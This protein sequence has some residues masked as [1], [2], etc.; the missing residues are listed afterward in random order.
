[1]VGWNIALASPTIISEPNVTGQAINSTY[2]VPFIQSR[3]DDSPGVFAEILCWHLGFALWLDSRGAWHLGL[4]DAGKGSK[5]VRKRWSDGSKIYVRY[6]MIVGYHFFRQICVG[7]EL[8]MFGSHPNGWW[9]YPL[10]TVLRNLTND[11]RKRMVLCWF[12]LWGIWYSD[13]Q[14]PQVVYLPQVQHRKM[15]KGSARF[16]ALRICW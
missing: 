5:F 9:G 3:D 6:N 1:M 13:G 12:P 7:L 8:D 16:K 10:P 14:Q 4:L 2:Q 11:R 15:G